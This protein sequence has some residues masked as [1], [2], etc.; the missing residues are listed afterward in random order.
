[1]RARTRE[2]RCAMQDETAAFA[3]YAR[4]MVTR[5]P[6]SRPIK[7]ETNQFKG[8]RGLR[9]VFRKLGQS[10]KEHWLNHF[11]VAI[12]SPLFP[13][14]NK[15]PYSNNCHTEM[16]MDLCPG[17]TVRIGTMY[18]YCEVDEN[19]KEVWLPGKLFVSEISRGEL[20]KYETF[21]LPA[22]REMET[23]LLCF[24]L[25]NLG[26][27]FNENTY[28]LRAIMPCPPGVGYYDPV[29]ADVR[30]EEVAPHEP[31]FCTQLTVLLMQAAAYENLR[32]QHAAQAHVAE[33]DIQRGWPHLISETHA[34]SHTPN[35][36]YI[37]LVGAPGVHT[38]CMRPDMSLNRD[39]KL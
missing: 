37:A 33:S 9:V 24:A 30:Q 3:D 27:P 15:P 4:R 18:K 36:L 13:P 22:T 35:S 11:A 38:A 29:A 17:C 5:I 19:G 12:T 23:R 32:Q 6:S 1:M 2:E 26:C 34:T 28:K 31:V 14:Y 10:E 21:Q 16:V 25:R 8:N 20:A 7:Y 39:G